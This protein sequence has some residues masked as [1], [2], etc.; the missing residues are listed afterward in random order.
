MDTDKKVLRLVKSSE[1]S[2]NSSSDDVTELWRVTI[3]GTRDPSFGKQGVAN[4]NLLASKLGKKR[5]GFGAVTLS[6]TGDIVLVGGNGTAFN[7]NGDLSPL[8]CRLVS[9]GNKP[10]DC[11]PQSYFRE[12]SVPGKALSIVDIKSLS[13]GSF[14]ALAEGKGRWFLPLKLAS[15]FQLDPNFARTPIATDF[16]DMISVRH[17]GFWI[18]ENSKSITVAINRCLTENSGSRLVLDRF[19]MSGKVDK[20]FGYNGTLAPRLGTFS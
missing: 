8:V 13:D 17:S 9:N 4:L 2:S 7:G 3:S 10:L 11:A 20:R 6:P 15:N 18:N 1:T 14:V 16:C 5:L 12:L 19:D